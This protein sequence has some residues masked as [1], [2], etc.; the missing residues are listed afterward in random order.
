MKLTESFGLF[1]T[2]KEVQDL[3]S[4]FLDNLGSPSAGTRRAACDCAVAVCQNS[5]EPFKNIAV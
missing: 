1:F 4:T 2:E 3:L 5:R